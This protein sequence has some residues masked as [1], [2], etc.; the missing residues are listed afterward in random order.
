[1][2]SIGMVLDVSFGW[3]RLGTHKKTGPA[4][5]GDRRNRPIV[6]EDSPSFQFLPD[7]G[8]AR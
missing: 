2:V 4:D 7:R 5:N 6:T 8:A 3:M 1:M